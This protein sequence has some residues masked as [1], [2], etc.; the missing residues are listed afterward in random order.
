MRSLFVSERDGTV[1]ISRHLPQLVHSSAVVG[2]TRLEV[3]N[4]SV[5]NWP[6]RLIE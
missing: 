4:Q 5:D 6:V 2:C 3:L 1:G